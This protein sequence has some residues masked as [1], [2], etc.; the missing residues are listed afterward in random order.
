MDCVVIDKMVNSNVPLSEAIKSMDGTF[1]DFSQSHSRRCFTQGNVNK[2]LTTSSTIYSYGK[3]RMVLPCEMM[4]FQGYPKTLRFPLH[5]TPADVR[6][7]AG[8]GMTLPCLATVLWSIIANVPLGKEAGST[9]T[10]ERPTDA[11]PSSAK[12]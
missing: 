5:A 2:C 9:S 7:F 11:G 1:L 3:D 4:A 12:A 8:E 10:S 6:D